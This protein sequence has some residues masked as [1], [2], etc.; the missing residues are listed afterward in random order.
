MWGREQDFVRP[1]RPC[2]KE[3]PSC[4]HRAP[5]TT[6]R[7]PWTK[8]VPFVMPLAQRLKGEVT[9]LAG[10]AHDTRPL[11]GPGVANENQGYWRNQK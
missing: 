1:G 7:S 10:L 6:G 9:C 2:V 8:V 4:S 11:E 3:L 5:R